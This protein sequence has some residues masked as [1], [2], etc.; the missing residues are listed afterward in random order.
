MRATLLIFA[1]A[2]LFFPG[3]GKSKLATVSG[4]I[5]IDGQPAEVGSIAFFPTNGKSPT[6]GGEIHSG[7]YTTAV[8]PGPAKVEIRVPKQVGEKKLY[9]TTSGPERPIFVELLP[10]KYNDATEL[11]FDVQQGNNQHDFSLTTK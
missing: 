11:Q 9:G 7:R 6:A 4:A 10:A 3:C 8:T 2:V 1:I 5:T